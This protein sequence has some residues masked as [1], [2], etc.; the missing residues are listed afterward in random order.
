[1][2]QD[3]S[4]EQFDLELEQTGLSLHDLTI[5]LLFY[6]EL[7]LQHMVTNKWPQTT[8]LMIE[9]KSEEKTGLLERWKKVITEF[10]Q[11]LK[12]CK[13]KIEIR[14]NKEQLVEMD[15]DDLIFSY[16]DHSTYHRGQLITTFKIVTRKKAMN[17]DYWTYLE[18][19]KYKKSS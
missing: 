13:G 2:L 14:I 19:V 18:E 11:K 4:K 12:E 15:F 3:V 6:Y 16:T 8:Q 10:A 5:H 17:T 9:L 1:M 7:W